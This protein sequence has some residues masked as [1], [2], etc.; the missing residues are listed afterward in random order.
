MKNKSLLLTLGIMAALSTNV[1]MADNVTQGP[2]D[3]TI[4]RT[5]DGNVIG[6]TYI[7]SH[8][9]SVNDTTRADITGG[10]DRILIEPNSINVHSGAFENDKNKTEGT[11]DKNGIFF[12]KLENDPTDNLHIKKSWAEMGL[13]YGIELNKRETYN[14]ELT[15]NDHRTILDTDHL[16]MYRTKDNGITSQIEVHSNGLTIYDNETHPNYPNHLEFNTKKVDVG[17]LTINNVAQ[18]VEDTDAVN[19]YQLKDYVDSNIMPVYSGGNIMVAEGGI[20]GIRPDGYMVS[21]DRDLSHLNSINLYDGNNESNYTLEGTSMI[22]RGDGSNGLE[23]HTKYRY[24]GVFINSNDG[25]ANPVDS[26]SLTDKGLDN[27]GHKITNVDRGTK[28][29]DAVNVS[30]LREV[31]NKINNNGSNILN[32]AKSYTDS[33]VAN[34]GAAS[35]ALSALHPID[36]D[37]GYKWQFATGFGNYKNKTAVALGLFYQPNENTLLSLGTTL[38]AKNNMVNGGATFRFGP[39]KAMNTN[40]QI[41]TDQKVQELELRLQAIEAKYNE[42]LAKNSK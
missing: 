34:I 32:E 11:I 39:S 38:G 18:G 6:N 17:G 40:K 5:S 29:T 2:G 1:A 37:K 12:H 10:P 36:F 28:S 20:P 14:G 13:D 15:D 27:G 35:A 24:N 7:T 3:V 21:L 23:Y 9:I 30:Q 4:W 41:A 8:S 26:V 19:V 33:Q 22:Y 31:E 16:R 42:L 25:D